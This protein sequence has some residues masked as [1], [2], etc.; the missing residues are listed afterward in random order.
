MKYKSIACVA[1]NSEKAQ[2]AYK[3][4]NAKYKFTSDSKADAILALG[5]DGFMLH[6]LHTYMD[7]GKPIYGMNCG[8]VGFLMNEY[9]EEDLVKHINNAC[10]VILHPLHMTA[11]T[12]DGREHHALALNEVSMFRQSKQA[13]N[14]KISVDGNVRLEELVSDGVLV[15]TPAG[16]TAYN[17]SVQG[18]IIPLGSDILALTPISPFRPRR[19]H[20][21]LLNHKAIVQIDVLDPKKRPVSAVAD[22]TEVRDVVSVEIMEER[23]KQIKLLFDPGHS[24]EERIIREQFLP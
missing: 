16:S 19:W 13:A 8:T 24:L 1:D 10:E 22:F 18:T 3:S 11:K 14:L 15:A 17:L 5:G 9:R 20:G 23:S 4:L 21:A 6:I 2:E 12:S 7:S